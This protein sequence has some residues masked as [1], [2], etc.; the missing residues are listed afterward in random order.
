M[1]TPKKAINLLLGWPARSLLP[2]RAIQAVATAVLTDPEKGEPAL[3]YGPDQGYPPLKSQIAVWLNHFYGRPPLDAEPAR[4]CISGGASQNFARILDVYADPGVTRN[5]WLVAP[6]Y[7]L[8]CRIL[9]DAGFAGRLRGV[10][11]DDQGIDV[12]YL[13]REIEKADAAQWERTVRPPPLEAR[14]G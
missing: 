11:E 2:L 7:H 6:C 13:E 8:A 1:A 10:P 14:K 3:L 5:A 12:Q 9:V 4:I